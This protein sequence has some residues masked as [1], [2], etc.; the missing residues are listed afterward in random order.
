VEKDRDEPKEELEKEDKPEDTTKWTSPR[1]SIIARTSKRKS[2]KKLLQ[3]TTKTKKESFEKLDISVGGS[4]TP[5]EGNLS[6]NENDIL[7]PRSE[8]IRAKSLKVRKVFSKGFS[9]TKVH[10]KDEKSNNADN[11]DVFSHPILKPSKSASGIPKVKGLS[12]SKKGEDAKDP[13]SP[14]TTR[15]GINSPQSVRERNISQP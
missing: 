12:K 6:S 8:L 5:H 7:S 2:A 4:P 15:D 14:R 3:G 10:D 1:A 11:S 9:S 13:I